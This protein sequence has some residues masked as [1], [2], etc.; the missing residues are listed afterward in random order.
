MQVTEA[1][2]EPQCSDGIVCID[3]ELTAAGPDT[4]SKLPKMHSSKTL[5]MPYHAMHLQV[6][7]GRLA[8]FVP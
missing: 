4:L 1:I 8:I 3:G 6:Q 2:W 5:P 7:P